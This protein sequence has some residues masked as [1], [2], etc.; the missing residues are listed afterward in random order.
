MSATIHAPG[1]PGA[2]WLHGPALRVLAAAAVVF[3]GFFPALWILLT[4]LKSEA[5]LVRKPLQWWPDR[6]TLANYLQAFTDQPLLRYLGNSAAVALGSTVLSLLV[7]AMAAYAIARDRK[8][9]R[10]NSSHATLSRMPSS[11]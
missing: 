7:S 4:S 5:E 9:T 1:M 6:L 3:N 10:L 2:G 8:S 11:A